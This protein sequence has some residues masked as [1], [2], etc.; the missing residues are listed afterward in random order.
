VKPVE[1]VPRLPGGDSEVMDAEGLRA[2][3]REIIPW[4][5][6]SV[7]ARLV[8][9]LVDRAARSASGWVP[10]GPTNDAAD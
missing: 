7:H 9:A 3:I 5:D 4:L 1:L 10:D 8:N 2:L 6:E